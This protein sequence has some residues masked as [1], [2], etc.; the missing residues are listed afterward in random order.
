MDA[1]VTDYGELMGAG[2]EIEEN[3]IAVARG[4]HSELLKPGGSAIDNSVSAQ[5]S[6][7]AED[8]DFAGR[9]ALRRLNRS[10]D[11][12]I[13]ELLK[14]IVGFHIQVSYQ[15]PLAPPPPKLPP[16]PLNPPPPPEPRLNP[17]PLTPPPMGGLQTVR[18]PLGP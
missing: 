15:L 11:F 5:V 10:N 16:P 9:L 13:I 14:K 18:L 17:P 12:G 4:R 8:A 2:H 1:L 6:F 7:G 3:G